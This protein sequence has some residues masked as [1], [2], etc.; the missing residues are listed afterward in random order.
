M[1]GLFGCSAKK[2]RIDYGGNKDCF[3]GAKDE[4]RAGEK[5]GQRAPLTDYNE[6]DPEP[7]FA[8]AVKGGAE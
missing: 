1:L 7:G 4:Y 6:N 5:E 3:K 8:D 2:Y